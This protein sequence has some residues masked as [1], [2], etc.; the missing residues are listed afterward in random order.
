MSSILSLRYNS[1]EVEANWILRLRTQMNQS[2]D[3][4]LRAGSER[5]GNAVGNVALSLTARLTVIRLT[6]SNLEDLFRELGDD[7][8]E[9]RS[10]LECCI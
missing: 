1:F 9:T 10:D 6:K 5:W 3:P 7:L 8:R 2:S 4:L